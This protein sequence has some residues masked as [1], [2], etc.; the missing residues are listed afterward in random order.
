MALPR[1]GVPRP[2]RLT[3]SS[4]ARQSRPK[5]PARERDLTHGRVVGFKADSRHANRARFA[6]LREG[7]S[8]S[9]VPPLWPL[10]G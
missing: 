6:T 5:F 2:S 10:G 7:F 3:E 4:K 9:D 8:P 1:D